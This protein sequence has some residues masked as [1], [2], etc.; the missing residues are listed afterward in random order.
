MLNFFL[1]NIYITL[2][3]TAVYYHI[4]RIKGEYFVRHP[5]TSRVVFGL[6]NGLIAFHLMVNSASVSAGTIVDLRHFMVIISAIGGGP[7]SAI[8]TAIVIGGT[9]LLFW[10]LSQGS[11]V[12][13]VSILVLALG[14][15]YSSRKNLSFKSRWI[16]CFFWNIAVGNIA[17]SYLL[18]SNPDYFKTIFYFSLATTV[19]SYYLYWLICYYIDFHENY[20]RISK[21]TTMD[22]LTGLNNV[23]GFDVE[24]NKAINRSSRKGERLAFLQIDIDFFKKIN[25]TYGHASGDVVLKKFAELLVEACRSFDIISRNGGEEFSVILQDCPAVH[26]IEVAERIRKTIEMTAFQING[27]GPIHITASVGVSAYPDYAKNPELL[28]AIADKALYQAKQSGRN[29]VVLY[30]EFNNLA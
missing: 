11:I 9:R 24:Y 6:I 22:F 20:I 15:S 26:A 19:L 18:Y 5:V 29:K 2:A 28:I 17:L 7:L 3:I 30:E 8:I 14:S 25:D 23:R 27:K 1:I 13:S 4:Y 16:G 21:E 10:S 12:A